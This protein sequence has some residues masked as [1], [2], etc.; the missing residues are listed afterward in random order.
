MMMM[1][2]ALRAERYAGWDKREAQAMLK[3]ARRWNRLRLA[4]PRKKIE[5]KPKSGRQ[6]YYENLLNRYR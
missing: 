1:D 3:K 4:S 5:P 2:D 6:E